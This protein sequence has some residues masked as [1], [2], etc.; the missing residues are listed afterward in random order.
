M[1]KLILPPIGENR[2]GQIIPNNLHIPKEG[3]GLCKWLIGFVLIYLT[4]A[5]PGTTHNDVC[6]KVSTAIL[7][8]TMGNATGPQKTQTPPP[9][10]KK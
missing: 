10:P 9:P 8:S 5:R 1:E 6:E 4:P 7:L 2:E 3:L